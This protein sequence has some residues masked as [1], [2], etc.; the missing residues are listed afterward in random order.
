MQCRMMPFDDYNAPR[1][2]QL[3]M[4]SNQYNLRTVRYI[5]AEI[6]AIQNDETRAGFVFDLCDRLSRHGIVAVV[7]LQQQEPENLFMENWLMSCRVL[8]RGMEHAVLQGIIACARHRGCAVLTG[9]YCPTGKN[10]LVAGHYKAMGFS[11]AGGLWRLN[12]ADYY[13][14]HTAITLQHPFL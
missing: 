8:R 5:D 2:A 1:A 13:P 3:S 11:F 9:E 10:A 12:I 6:A 7:V 4:R 14:Q